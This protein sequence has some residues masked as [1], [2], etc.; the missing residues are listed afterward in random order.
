ME[1]KILLHFNGESGFFKKLDIA[2]FL[3]KHKSS[4][5]IQAFASGYDLN[6]LQLFWKENF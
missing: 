2:I 3:K 6:L 1:D 5:T 4:L